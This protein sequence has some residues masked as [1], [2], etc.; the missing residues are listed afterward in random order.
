MSNTRA[1]TTERCDSLDQRSD[2]AGLRV[3][4]EMMKRVKAVHARA[5]A[6]RLRLGPSRPGQGL[7]ACAATLHNSSSRD[8]DWLVGRRADPPRWSPRGR[9]TSKV[10]QGRRRSRHG[11]AQ[12]AW[13]EERAW[14]RRGGRG[15]RT[16]PGRVASERETAEPIESTQTKGSGGSFNLARPVG[17]LSAWPRCTGTMR[18]SA[19]GRLER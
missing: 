13:R 10:R 19:L 8:G 2:H 6:S 12:E 4:H 18:A 1:F 14:K 17:A 3:S 16:P 5:E 15:E 11:G 9:A 7:D